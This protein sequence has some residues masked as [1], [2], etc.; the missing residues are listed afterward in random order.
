MPNGSLTIK[1]GSPQGEGTS[2]DD[3]GDC[4]FQTGE[5]PIYLNPNVSGSAEDSLV[6]HDGQ[7]NEAI[8]IKGDGEILIEG[9]SVVNDPEIYS[10]FIAFFRTS[11]NSRCLFTYMGGEHHFAW[12]RRKRWSGR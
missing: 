2:G 8:L 3:G 11:S 4:L 9:K 6:I 7:G 10:A 1:T 5:I 12:E